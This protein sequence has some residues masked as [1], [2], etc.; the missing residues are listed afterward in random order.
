MQPILL[1]RSFDNVVAIECTRD[2]MDLA[3]IFLP[4]FQFA[5]RSFDMV[6][7]G[8]SLSWNLLRS[9]RRYSFCVLLKQMLNVEAKI[10]FAEKLHGTYEETLSSLPHLWYYHLFCCCLPFLPPF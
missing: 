4:P 8:L 3:H 6:V 1:V 5:L 2:R 10:A 9:M 7:T